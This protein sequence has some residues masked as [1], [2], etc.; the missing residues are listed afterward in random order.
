[1]GKSKNTGLGNLD[2]TNYREWAQEAIHK[3]GQ[4]GNILDAMIW[5]RIIALYEDALKAKVPA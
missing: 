2:A 4:Q 1:M 5:G 3:Y